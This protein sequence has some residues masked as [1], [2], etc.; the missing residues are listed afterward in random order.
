M[1][2]MEEVVQ[3]L[4]RIPYPIWEG[5][6]RNEP[7]WRFT[8]PVL[9]R[10][11]P[12]RFLTFMV[13]A[14]LN[15]YQLKGPAE[16]R[17]WPPLVE[18]VIQRPIPESPEDLEEVLKGFYEKERLRTA[19]I[20]R[21]KRFL[22]SPLAHRMWRMTPAE[23]SQS[24]R[25][26]WYKIAK[27]MGQQKEKKTIVFS[28]KCLGIGILMLGVKEFDFAG[29]PIPVDSRVRDLLK[30]WGL[31]RKVSESEIQSICDE[32]LQGL[33]RAE[34][35]VN[36]IH[37]DSLLWQMEGFYL[38]GLAFKRLVKMGVGVDLARAIAD[39]RR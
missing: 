19:K 5:F 29:I 30:R 3:I 22:Q 7:E 25:A 28:M 39:L 33:R 20:R 13:M 11:G 16:K 26:L 14:G 2:S 23:F 9:E 4:C 12:S 10:Y 15:D 21:L 1:A 32:M 24:F 17:Y 6:V 34:P 38:Q 27:T 31:I 18:H 37:L 35:A 36:M 8:E